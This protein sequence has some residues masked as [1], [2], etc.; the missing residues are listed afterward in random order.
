MLPVAVCSEEYEQQRHDEEHIPVGK[1]PST[2]QIYNNNLGD[3][4]LRGHK[5][6]L[7]DSNI[8]QQGN[9]INI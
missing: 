6:V 5:Q 9:Y 8:E 7:T 1:D 4:A 2:N 3:V